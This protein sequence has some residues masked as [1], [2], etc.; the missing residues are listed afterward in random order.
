MVE[1]PEKQE[2]LFSLIYNSTPLSISKFKFALY[3]EKF[4][5][6]PE[7]L[8][9]DSLTVTGDAP[10]AV[11]SE[12]VKG[13]QGYPIDLKDEYIYDLLALCEEWQTP[14]LNEII[15]HHIKQKP[16]YDQICERVSQMQ[17]ES[18]P[19]S[20]L[21]EILANNLNVVLNLP[22]FQN[23]P[24][25]VIARILSNPEI[26]VDA[27]LLYSFIMTMFSK[28]GAE[29]SVLAPSLDIRKLTAEEAQQFLSSPNLVPSFLNQSLVPITVQMMHDNEQL[30]QRI[31]KTDNLLKSVFDRLDQIESKVQNGNFDNI[32]FSNNNTA[33]NQN[34]NNSNNNNDNS[35]PELSNRILEL[36][37]II[38]NNNRAIESIQAQLAEQQ[39]TFKEQLDEIEKKAHRDVR[40]TNKIVNGLTRKAV[41]YDKLFN[42]VK[43]EQNNARNG[44]ADISKVANN[45]QNEIMALKTKMKQ[46][47]TVD[48]SF[49]GRPFYGIMKT[50]S[51]EANQNAHLAGIV[52]ITASSSD[53]NEAYQVIDMDWDDLFF[54]ENKA[55]Q[56]I[57]FDFK[58][59]S[60]KLDHY[61]IKTH[62]FP[63]NFPHL[64]YWVI[65]G[66]ND[67]NS[68]DEIDRRA[69]TVLNGK[70]K[71]QT[72]PCK[73]ADG[74]FRFIRLRQTGMNAKGTFVLALTNIELFGQ[75][76]IPGEE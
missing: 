11:F 75:L 44:I 54:T 16:D 64:K 62:K 70:N 39:K 6:I 5:S 4:R 37:T 23:F 69:I 61:T 36:E 10:L 27:H 57:Q 71:F 56:W 43:V 74:T 63:S 46:I 49:S 60:V 53:H 66:S 67:E 26:V 41:A 55:N 20:D 73:K 52:N 12:F 21:E 35:N 29:A 30:Q 7:F 1:E 76:Y 42:E 18:L 31:N 68:W 32:E 24:L 38:S 33:S 72:F 45:L 48:L 8:T 2:E 3:S 50:L 15:I 19:S 58:E 59:K 40:K 51:V 14:T 9:S 25:P 65:E 47:K 13:A 34:S 28:Y 22:S 17:T